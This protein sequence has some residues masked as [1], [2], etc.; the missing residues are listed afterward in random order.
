MYSIKG[1]SAH[2]HMV[3]INA[4]DFMKLKAGMQIMMTSTTGGS[5]THVVLVVCA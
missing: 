3:T 1:N 4:S 2:D 5:H